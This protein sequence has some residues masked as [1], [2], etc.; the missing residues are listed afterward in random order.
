VQKYIKL[1]EEGVFN[2]VQIKVFRWWI[3]TFLST[4]IRVILDTVP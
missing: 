2:A 1:V 4:G 3:R